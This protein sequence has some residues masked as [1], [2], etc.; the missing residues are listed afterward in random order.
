MRRPDGGAVRGGA[1]GGVRR[2]RTPRGAARSDSGLTGNGRRGHNAVLYGAWSGVRRCRAARRRLER[3]R[4]VRHRRKR[5]PRGRR[6]M[7]SRLP[8]GAGARSSRLGQDRAG[9]GTVRIRSQR[10]ELR[11]AS[12]L[13]LSRAPPNRRDRRGRRGRETRRPPAV[14]PCRCGL[15][16]P[17]TNRPVLARAVH[18]RR[19][20]AEPG[21]DAD[22][23]VPAARRT[24]ARRTAWPRSSTAPPARHRRR[25]GSRA[26]SRRR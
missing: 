22:Q 20:R 2:S 21:L 14:R 9:G 19:H 11:P 25:R 26:P 15:N 17:A 23:G 6:P 8:C 10:S 12:V 4:A 13:R 1:R 24:A 7:R 18:G 3:L 16:R 5:R